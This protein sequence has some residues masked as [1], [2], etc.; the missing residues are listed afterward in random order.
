MVST[1]VA[2]EEED[3]EPATAAA[4]A[5]GEYELEAEEVPLHGRKSPISRISHGGGIYSEPADSPHSFASL[6][7]WDI[8]VK[9]KGSSV[10]CSS[11]SVY[12]RMRLL[13]LS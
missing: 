7:D 13:A 11:V 9:A 3:E 2:A 1:E 5:P 10:V 12:S 4:V 6:D 8:G